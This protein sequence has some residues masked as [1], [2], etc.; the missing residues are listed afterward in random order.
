MNVFSMTDVHTV[1]GDSYL[2]LKFLE[3]SRLVDILRSVFPK[4]KQDYEQILCHILHG[5]MKDGSKISYD[6]Y[7]VESF[8]S[9]VRNNI[10]LSSLRMNRVFFKFMGEC[11]TRMSFFTAS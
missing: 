5:V 10:P 3:K 9:Y 8:A 7:M 1:F 11:S 6:N 2:L 4:K